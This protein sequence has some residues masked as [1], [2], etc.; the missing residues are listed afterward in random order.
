MADDPNTCFNALLSF[1]NSSWSIGAVLK[2][3]D[4][5]GENFE[6]ISQDKSVAGGIY[7]SGINTSSYF[8]IW[9]IG[10]WNQ[11]CL[12]KLKTDMTLFI[13]EKE[14]KKVSNFDQS[15]LSG[16]IRLMNFKIDEMITY[17]MHGEVTDLQIWDRIVSPSENDSDGNVLSWKDVH[18]TKQKG[19]EIL[20]KDFKDNSNKMLIYI[21]NDRNINRSSYFCI[22]K[23]REIAVATDNKTLKEMQNSLVDDPVPNSGKNYYFTGHV[24]YLNKW[25][26]IKT[27]Q[28]LSENV[29]QIE[30]VFSV[31]LYRQHSHFLLCV[32]LDS[33]DGFGRDSGQQRC[34]AFNL[35]NDILREIPCAEELRP[36]CMKSGT[37][38]ISLFL[39]CFF[40]A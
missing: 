28:E 7:D 10:V 29:F 40:M 6:Q 32:F 3:G 2:S 33:S 9:N 18:L 20:E 12:Q 36:V 22:N 27:Y 30:G 13:N 26:N 15:S 38:M 1:D 31:L 25:I 37:P 39:L 24:K 19:Q 34:L 16:N 5:A 14:V 17:P 21:T 4:S 8:S 11:F 23:G 35:H